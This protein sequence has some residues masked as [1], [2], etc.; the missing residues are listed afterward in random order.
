MFIVA[1]KSSAPQ[2]SAPDAGSAPKREERAPDAGFRLTRERLA[3]WLAWLAEV[4]RLSEP[5]KNQRGNVARAQAES[6]A[7]SRHGLDWNAVGAIEEIAFGVVFARQLAA[8]LPPDKADAGNPERDLAA[9]RA[10]YGERAI[11]IVLEREAE[12]TRAWESL[13]GLNTTP[14]QNLRFPD[15]RSDPTP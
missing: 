11:R 15:P 6:A 7:L 5:D 8:I 13:S 3:A 4:Q 9:L 1:C 10:R 14:V 2:E 12:V